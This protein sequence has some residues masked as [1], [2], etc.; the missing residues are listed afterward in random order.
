MGA[1]AL[2]PPYRPRTMA[3]VATL[4]LSVSVVCFNA[5]RTIARVLDS[6]AGLADEVVVLDSGSTDS[7]PELVRSRP[8]VMLIDQPWLGYV[9]QKQAALERCSRPWVLHLDADE[10]LEPGLRDEVRKAIERDDAAVAGYELNRKVW[11]AGRFLD[12]AWQPEYRLRLVRRERARW[13]GYDPHDRM[14]I[15]PPPGASR[16]ERL[17]GDIRHECVPSIGEFLARQASHARTAAGALAE[18]GRQGSVARMVFSPLGEFAKQ[19]VVRGAWRDGWRGWVAS[20]AS[21]VAVAMK[22]AALIEATRSGA[23][24]DRP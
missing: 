20:S 18:R 2:T 3:R 1:L 23:G 10:S 11:Y 17:H 15:L 7:T 6:V 19:V 22:H 9:K 5:E 4:P 14:E 21:S 12:H 8:G 24:E 13:T 16:V